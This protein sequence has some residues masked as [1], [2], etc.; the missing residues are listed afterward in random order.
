[1][2]SSAYAYL[3]DKAGLDKSHARW[4]ELMRDSVSADGS[5]LHEI[6]RSATSNWIGG[7][8]KGIKGMAYTHYALLPAS[9]SAKIFA[10]QGQPVWKTPEGQLLKSAFDKAAAWTRHPETF[11][12]YASNNGK[13]EA[14]RNAA[15]FALLQNYY[16]NKDAEAVLNDG[17]KVGLN[18]FYLL[19]L[20]GSDETKVAGE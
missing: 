2:D 3:G 9:L 8:D 5:M 16:P 14:V 1:M 10:D 17:E 6:E 19:E 15:Y 18:G 20:F 11:P 7:P 13:L 12:Y 4:N